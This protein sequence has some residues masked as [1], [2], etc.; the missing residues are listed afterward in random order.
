[1]AIR[2]K[3]AAENVSIDI[4]CGGGGLA[5]QRLK[6]FWRRNEEETAMA[7]ARR[8]SKTMKAENK[9]KESTWRCGRK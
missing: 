8:Q 4:L 6:I 5:Y 7:K 1:L 2:R 9:L 3:L